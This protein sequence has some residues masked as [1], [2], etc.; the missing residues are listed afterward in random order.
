[1]QEMST[2]EKEGLSCGLRSVTDFSG[3]AEENEE[4]KGERKE[5]GDL[6]DS[7]WAA[8]RWSLV[9]RGQGKPLG[10]DD[11]QAAVPLGIQ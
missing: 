8:G 7:V 11:S 10:G 3:E 2:R 6:V 4:R 9:H 1:M 5:T